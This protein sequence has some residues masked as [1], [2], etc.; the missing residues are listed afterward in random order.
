MKKRTK[1]RAGGISLNHNGI[2]VR[3][4]IRAGW[5]GPGDK[6]NP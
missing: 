5:S 2:K 6:G 3:T 1:V 4:K